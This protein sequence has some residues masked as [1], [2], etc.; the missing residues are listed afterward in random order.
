MEKPRICVVL[1]NWN[2]RE[3]TLA[4]LDSLKLSDY[5]HLD[6]VVVD[7][8]S[9]DGIVEVLRRRELHVKIIANEKNLGFAGGNNQG[10]RYGLETGA[11]YILLLNNDTIVDRRCIS[12]LLAAAESNSA[13]GA[14]GP[15]IYYLDE[16]ERI[17]SAGGTVDF[18]ENAGR[19]RGY[20]QI[21][22]GQFDQTAEVDFISG[23]AVMV[24]RRVVEAVGL[25]CEDFYPGYYEDVDWSMRIQA[26]GYVNLVVPSAK[27]WHKVSA[28]TG[29]DYSPTSKYLLGYHA[30]TFMRRY[31]KPANWVKF[32]S[33]AVLSLPFVWTKESLRGRGASVIAKARGLRDGFLRRPLSTR[34]F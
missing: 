15:K 33:Y 27:V 25:L 30:V 1:L 9:Q 13:V 32:L 20:G 28:T 17:W 4:C 21:D 10:I 19:T 31:A 5:P 2:G 34:Y 7:Q 24:P 8:G 23:C 12:E 29:G 11:D 22:R 26:A 6:I 3:D 16:P 18:T 14:V